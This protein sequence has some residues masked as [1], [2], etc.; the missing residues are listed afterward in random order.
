ML[1]LFSKLQLYSRN[2]IFFIK[3]QLFL[4]QC[5]S[6]FIYFS[7]N[8][9]LNRKMK[10]KTLSVIFFPVVA[11]SPVTG[12]TELFVAKGAV[13]VVVSKRSVALDPVDDTLTRRHAGC[14]INKS[15]RAVSKRN[16]DLQ[17]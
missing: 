17:I 3:F 5:N 15:H 13:A 14:V 4:R 12:A 11:L 1:T 8:I 9:D 7:Q 6:K 10:K 2:F 16:S